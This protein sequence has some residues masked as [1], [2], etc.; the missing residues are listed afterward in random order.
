MLT[1]DDIERAYIFVSSE[2]KYGNSAV[3][4]PETGKIFYKS[5]LSG[6]DEIPEDIDEF[7]E[8]YIAIP[9]EDDLDLGRNLVFEFV[10]NYLPDQFENVRNIFRDRGAYRRYKFLLIKVGMLEAWYQFENDKTNSVLRKWCQENGL[11]LAD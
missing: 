5:D 9:H 11:Q 4:N 10:R 8:K 6:I 7:P 3:V 1:F 2:Q